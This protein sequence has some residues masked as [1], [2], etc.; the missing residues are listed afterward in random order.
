[1][2]WSYARDIKTFPAITLKVSDEGTGYGTKNS[3]AS[4]RFKPEIK[5]YFEK[6][7]AYSQNIYS[8]SLPNITSRDIQDFRQ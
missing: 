7:T 8:E 3:S 5:D 1:M 2:E 4:Y 6:P